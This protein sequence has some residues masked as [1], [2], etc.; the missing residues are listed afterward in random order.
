MPIN[1]TSVSGSEIIS[2]LIV[3]ANIVNINQATNLTSFISLM[4]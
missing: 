1:I 4:F 2:V 3:K